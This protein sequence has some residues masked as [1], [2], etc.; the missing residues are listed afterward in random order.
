VTPLLLALA[1]AAAPPPQGAVDRF[2]SRFDRNRD[3]VIDPKEWPGPAAEFDRLDRN[4]DGKLSREELAEVKDRLERLLG[5]KGKAAK[6]KP[7]E[8]N[9][10]AAKGERHADRL[11]VGDAAPDFTLPDLSGKKT[12]TLS[13]YRDKKPVVLIFGS[14]T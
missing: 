8:V 3:G 7:G 12:I 10:P 14:F 4:G 9:T 2:L 1:F 13:S 6:D 11:K 5:G